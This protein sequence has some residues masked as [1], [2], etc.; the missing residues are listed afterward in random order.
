MLILLG[1]C[2]QVCV[3]KRDAVEHE[4]HQYQY[5][6]LQSNSQNSQTVKAYRTIMRYTSSP[7][8]DSLTTCECACVV[9]FEDER[10]N[11]YLFKLILYIVQ[12]RCL[13]FFKLKYTSPPVQ[14][15]SHEI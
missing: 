4:Y 10:F 14:T 6:Q 7:R 3:L 2:V 8:Y 13:F 5:H 12:K 9:S 11:T 15:V 1:M